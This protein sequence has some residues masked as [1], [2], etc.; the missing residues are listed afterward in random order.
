VAIRCGAPVIQTFIVPEPGFRYRLDIVA[1]L[2]DPADGLDEDAAVASAMQTYA[3]N[4]EKY[5]REQPALLTRA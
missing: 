4:L 3:A 1:T 5:I 2:V